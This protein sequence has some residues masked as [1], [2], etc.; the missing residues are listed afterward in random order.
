MVAN[1]FQCLKIGA[2]IL[3]IHPGQSPF[4]FFGYLYISNPLPG[5]KNMLGRFFF[6]HVADVSI[7]LEIVSN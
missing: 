6:E 7:K 3:T 5:F 1:R 2:K 4:F